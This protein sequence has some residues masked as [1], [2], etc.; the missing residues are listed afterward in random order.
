MSSSSLGLT[1]YSESALQPTQSPPLLPAP[2]P[3]A[4]PSVSPESYKVES[5]E[6]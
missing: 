2:V 6:K 4:K 3:T 1:E 5:F